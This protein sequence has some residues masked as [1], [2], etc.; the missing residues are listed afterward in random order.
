MVLRIAFDEAQLA[1]YDFGS[2]INFKIYNEPDPF[3]G[4]YTAFDASTY[5]KAVLKS[6]KRHG[7]RAFFF[8][9]VERAITVT[10][11]LAQVIGDVDVTWDT[12]ASGIGHFAY[13]SQLRPTIPGYLWLEVEL[14][15]TGAQVSTELR[16]VYINPSEAA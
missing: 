8:R 3:L 6:F 11:Q 10:G 13:T 14:Q 12:Q 15:K 4:T 1:R 9:D 5:T 16:R 7:D 2:D